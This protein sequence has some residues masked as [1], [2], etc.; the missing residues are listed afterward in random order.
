MTEKL[1]KELQRIGLT[2]NAK[3]TKNLRCNPDSED[4][5]LNFVE[6][7]DEFI[8][9]MKDTDSQRYLGRLLWTSVSDRVKIEAR[10]R[11]RAAWTSFLKYKSVFLIITY[12]YNSD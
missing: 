10:N 5:N 3:N 12:P 2:L 1:I 6:I 8:K 11:R 9:V 4:Y 7:G